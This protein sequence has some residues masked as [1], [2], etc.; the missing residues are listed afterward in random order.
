MLTALPV[1]RCIPL[2]CSPGSRLGYPNGPTSY[3]REASLSEKLTS[4]GPPGDRS[5]IMGVLVATE[6][7]VARPTKR[8]IR[9]TDGNR[10]PVATTTPSVLQLLDMMSE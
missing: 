8:S 7:K 10:R 2:V 9:V 6:N 4:Q 1:A 3:R 5:R